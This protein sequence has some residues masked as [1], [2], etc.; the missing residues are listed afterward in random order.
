MDNIET[1]KEKNL[2]LRFSNEKR[3]DLFIKVSINKSLLFNLLEIHVIID[4]VISYLLN[5]KFKSL[6]IIVD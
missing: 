4:F 6:K 5:E 2:K 3:R 1:I